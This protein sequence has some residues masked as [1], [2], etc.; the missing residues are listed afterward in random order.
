MVEK[1][2]GSILA[3]LYDDTHPCAERSRRLCRLEI[4]RL[5][6]CIYNLIFNKNPGIRHYCNVLV[7]LKF[8]K[9]CGRRRAAGRAG[10]L[11][12]SRHD[13][14]S[15]DDCCVERSA[16]RHHVQTGTGFSSLPP[17]GRLDPYLPRLLA[18]LYLTT[19]SE[20]CKKS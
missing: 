4:D 16:G 1:I 15:Q 9:F 5:T 12:E 17:S 18:Q 3:L 6:I 2:K 14:R 7:V 11:R 8:V 10:P 19:L 20:I 13:R